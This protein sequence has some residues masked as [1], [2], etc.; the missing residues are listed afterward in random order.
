LPLE[1]SGY[2][3][4]LSHSG[5]SSRIKA[6]AHTGQTVFGVVAVRS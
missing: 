1:Q 4:L 5:S 2:E 3:P 6:I